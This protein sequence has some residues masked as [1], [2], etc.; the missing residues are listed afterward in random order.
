M[1][2]HDGGV[3][4]IVVGGR[5]QYGPMQARSGVRGAQ[6][7]ELDA[8]TRDL[9]NLIQYGP[10]EAV[11]QIQASFPSERNY[12]R[13][14]AVSFNLRD[15]IRANESFPLQF[16]YEPADCRIFYTPETVSNF[17][18]LWLY[19]ANVAWGN[20]TCVQG[21]KGVASSYGNGTGVAGSNGTSLN[22]SSPTG[23]SPPSPTASTPV[24]IGAASKVGGVGLAMFLAAGLAALI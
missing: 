15:Q 7:Y 16:A 22:G 20:G 4:T 19:V 6:S 21:S 12:Y 1:F 14:P 11:A 13:V 18:N 23:G 17:A 9:A 3:R 24:V 5:P 10:P 2:K 8:L